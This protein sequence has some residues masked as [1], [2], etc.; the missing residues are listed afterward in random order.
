MVRAIKFQT[1]AS[2]T[3]LN[4][5]QGIFATATPPAQ[6]APAFTN[7]P[8]PSTTSP[9]ATYNFTY[10]A[11]GNPAPSFSVTPN[12]LPPGLSLTSAGVLSGTP[13]VPGLYTGTVTASNNIGTA[14]TQAFTIAV[15][16]ATSITNGSPVT[17]IE[18]NT[19]YN[20]TY[21]TSGYPAPTFSVTPPNSLPTGLSLILAGSQAGVLSGTPTATGTFTGTISASNGIGTAVAQSFSITVAAGQQ[22]TD[23]ETSNGFTGTATIIGPSATPQNDGIANLQKYFYDI[24]PSAPMNA[25]D[26]AALPTLGMTTIGGSQYVT[27]TYREYALQ[28]G[29]TVNVQSSPDLKIWNTLTNPMI[30]LI[31]NDPSTSTDDP[32]MQ[33]RVAYTGTKQFFRLNITQP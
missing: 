14:A 11:S 3:Y 28:T 22:F 8:P 29:I 31:G 13:T 7:G 4:P 23:W 25:T 26:Y 2:G 21:T 16:Q 32:I 33:V 1:T 30:V 24:N 5:S 17:T 27:L 12:S 19:P 9:G 20:F 6:T 15:Q 18:L 10:A